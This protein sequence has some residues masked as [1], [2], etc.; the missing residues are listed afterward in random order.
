MISCFNFRT[1]KR[2]DEAEKERLFLKNGGLLL[3]ALVASCDGKCNPIRSFSSEE[4]MKATNNYDPQRV[5]AEDSF[6]ILYSGV[7][8][9]RPVSVK[10]YYE[11]SGFELSGL[12]INDIV[13]GSQMSAHNNALKLLGCCLETK[14]PTIVYE[15]MGDKTLSQFI[16]DTNGTHGPLLSWKHRI[17]IAM[18]IA[19]GV[20]YLHN[21]LSR[22]VI[23]RDI[24]PP[25][26]VLDQEFNAKLFDFSLSIAIP[27]GQS[28]VNDVVVGTS[29]FLAKEYLCSGNAT[30]KVDVYSFGV[31]LIQLLT[32]R[33]AYE[34]VHIYEQGLE[35]GE[36]IETVDASILDEGIE[37]QDLLPFAT[38]ARS[39]V[40]DEAEDRPT[41]IHVAKE[42][43][44]I[45]QS[46][47]VVS[48]PTS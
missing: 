10:R 31:V 35:I 41:M 15:F 7:L 17:K 24:K 32:R 40:C 43:K 47:P 11:E 36:L 4:L 9:D 8:Q 18:G 37:L 16:D 13:I 33:K 28:Y 21:A 5:I 42:L 14:Y 3:E 38:L 1:Q 44:Q 34:F 46:V 23:H 19:N 29:S 25:F 26:I 39:C 2:K 20:A 45:Y 6:F 22:P 27:D 48:S 12:A 30:E